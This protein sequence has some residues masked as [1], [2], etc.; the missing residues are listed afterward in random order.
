MIDD[1]GFKA[2]AG[3]YKVVLTYKD[4]KAE[5]T[6]K[7]VHDYEVTIIATAADV[8]KGDTAFDV[9]SVF[10]LRIGSEPVTV[11]ADMISGRVDVDRVGKY[12]VE[13]TYDRFGQIY[14]NRAVVNVLPDVTI[15]TPSGDDF[16]LYRG[17]RSNSW[18]TEGKFVVKIDGRTI[19]VTS[20][21][22]TTDADF[23]KAG[24][25]TAQCSLTVDGVEFSKEIKYEIVDH[26][27]EI[28]HYQN[29]VSYKKGEKQESEVD[30][31]KFFTIKVN[32]S[33]YESSHKCKFVDAAVADQ[34]EVPEGYTLVPVTIESNVDYNAIGDYQV[35]ISFTLDGRK[36]EDTVDVHI[37]NNITVSASSSAVSVLSGT[38]S[39]DYKSLFTVKN[40]T[41]TVPVTD[42][43]ID[44]SAVDLQT[45]GT[46]TVSCTYEGVTAEK[47]ITV[48][49]SAFVGSYAALGDD[50]TTLSVAADGTV[51]LVKA[52]GTAVSGTYAAKADG[53]LQIKAGGTY[54]CIYKDGLLTFARSAA[55][56]KDTDCYVFAK[57]GIVLEKSVKGFLGSA[58]ALSRVGDVEYIVSQVKS[59]TT[60]HNIIF[61]WKYVSNEWDDWD[62]AYVDTYSAEYFIDPLIS[63]QL[64]SGVAEVE[65]GTET[66]VFTFETIDESV[67][68]TAAL[69][70]SEPT[71]PEVGPEKGDY[72]GAKGS[73]KLDGAGKA[74]VDG[75]T[76]TTTYTV[77]DGKIY[78]TWRENYISKYLVITLNGNNYEVVPSDGFE[79]TF[80]AASSSSTYIRFYGYGNVETYGVFGYGSVMGDYVLDR[81]G[82]SVKITYTDSEGEIKTVIFELTNGDNV[83]V[84]ADKLYTSAAEFVSDTIVNYRVTPAQIRI[85]VGSKLKNDD[86]FTVEYMDGGVKKTMVLT[87]DMID[88]SAVETVK[89]GYYVA[90]LKFE[91]DGRTYADF[92][93]IEVYEEPYR[94]FD[95]IGTYYFLNYSSTYS[96]ELKT[97]GTAYYTTYSTT[98]GTWSIDAEGRL[99]INCGSYKFSG[100]YLDGYLKI[101][102]SSSKKS[103]FVK[104]ATPL[105]NYTGS[106]GEVLSVFE[107]DGVTNYFYLD[108]AGFYGKVNVIFDGTEMTDKTIITVTKRLD[109]ELKTLLL[110]QL[111]GSDLVAAGTE[112]GTY[113]GEKGEVWLDGF[114]NATLAGV[115]AVY[116]V[117]GKYVILTVGTDIVP[118]VTDATALSYTVATPDAMIGTYKN[119][120]GYSTT[121]F[122]F[123]GFGTATYK[124]SYSETACEYTYDPETA[125]VT[126]QYPSYS[127]VYTIVFSIGADGSLTV[128]TSETWTFSVGDVFN[129]Q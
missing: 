121:T 125:T 66:V 100:E 56:V 71:E 26:I 86:L 74:T 28:T 18:A 96:L 90:T 127:S 126:V 1:G 51:S 14:R 45:A 116:T 103:Y 19:P 83:L 107:I 70:G 118:L 81:T 13:L 10:D 3:T 43:M 94:D 7:V 49:D 34:T 89:A 55:N 24:H 23:S 113:S 52:G 62:M 128:L 104:D 92:A 112:R 8:V 63:G 88:I 115:Q 67:T 42:A 17:S 11:T 29:G 80:K 98:A 101:V 16:T 59:G 72:T 44:D 65:I 4:Q 75:I 54:N 99:Q 25:Y 129:K 53:T 15:E 57:S 58:T 35:K 73:I 109:G 102:D 124:T 122:V 21:M 69:K 61:K 120:G 78:L 22:L 119:T 12:T 97:D 50:T 68:F 30:P 9:R 106:A 91:A 2:E 105:K 47:S 20:G 95:E 33:S 123:D 36:Y 48:I 79:Y 46:Y 60:V 31:L 85:P 27:C 40:L 117:S 64:F 41:E 114:G 5:S 38:A 77:K 110:A 32:E 108:A 84:T 39:Y 6:V 82:H 111:Q 76:V 87:G 93:I 37:T